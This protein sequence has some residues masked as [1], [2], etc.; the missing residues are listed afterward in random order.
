[1]TASAGAARLAQ[2]EVVDA[3]GHGVRLI[4]VHAWPLTIGRAL[5]NDI[6]LPDPHV[7][8]HHVTVAPDEQGA[9]RVSVGD[10]RNGVRIEHGRTHALL[11]GHEQSSLPALARLHLGHSQLLLRLPDDPLAA[12]LPLAHGLAATPRGL[13]PAL[14]VAA[15]LWLLAARW[16][17]SDADTRWNEYLAPLLAG[18]AALFLW[19]L[20]WGLASKLFTGRF[21][22]MAHLRLALVFGLAMQ[23]L[24]LLLM[25]GAFTFDWPLLSHLRPAATAVVGALWF[26]QHLRQVLPRHARAAT[27]WVAACTVLGLAVAMVS[28]W[29]RHDRVLEELYAPNLMPPSWRLARGAPVQ[30]LVNDLRVLEQPLRERAAKAQAEDYEP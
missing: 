1:M 24:D 4:D 25:V 16:I 17:G 22:L 2:A 21:T 10:S 20:V 6:V 30:Q 3:A 28:S 29:R 18:G 15:L 5:D 13:V 8:A 23:G 7:A 9:L 19:C 12:E 11:R 14:A 26:A 27:A